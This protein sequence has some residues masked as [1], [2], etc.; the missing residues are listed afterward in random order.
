MVSGWWGVDGSFGR[1]ELGEGGM[2]V[3]WVRVGWWDGVG[4]LEACGFLVDMGW[5]EKGGLGE[6]VERRIEG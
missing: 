1:V 3:V 2:W 4:G 6:M 5:R